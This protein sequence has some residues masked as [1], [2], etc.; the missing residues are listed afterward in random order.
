MSRAGG[1]HADMRAEWSKLQACWQATREQW[2]DE[3]ADEFER[4][5]WQEWEQRV[6]AYLSALEELEEIA[7]RALRETR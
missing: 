6:P 4:H 7:S 2:R 3:V 5:R 1:I